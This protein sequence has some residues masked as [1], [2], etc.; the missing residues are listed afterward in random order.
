MIFLE[1][2]IHTQELGFGQG[3]KTQKDILGLWVDIRR[4]LQNF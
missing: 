3:S 4:G 2:F 1:I